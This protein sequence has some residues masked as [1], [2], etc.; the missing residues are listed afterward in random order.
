MEELPAALVNR[1]SAVARARRPP[2]H[3]CRSGTKKLLN[4]R[5]LQ[6]DK[7][8]GNQPWLE[9]SPCSPPRVSRS[10][11]LFRYRRLRKMC[12]LAPSKPS[13]DT[14]VARS[15]IPPKI[16][17]RRSKRLKVRRISC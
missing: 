12:S 1:R 16:S 13:K 14:S 9:A 8:E 2:P 3:L 6:Q 17:H 10:L 11:Q 15:G 5:V 4:G 7:P